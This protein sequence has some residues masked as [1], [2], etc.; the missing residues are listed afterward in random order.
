[1]DLIGN[2][3]GH[4]GA[5]LIL[6][7][8]LF[9]GQRYVVRREGGK[10]HSGTLV[11]REVTG[12]V[13]ERAAAHPSAST[14]RFLV[15]TV[16][17]GVSGLQVGNKEHFDVWI[18]V[19]VQGGF[20]ARSAARPSSKGLLEFDEMSIEVASPSTKIAVVVL[21]CH[22]SK[23]KFFVVGST[24]GGPGVDGAHPAWMLTF[25]GNLRL[26]TID[27]R[28]GKARGEVRLS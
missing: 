14:D 11:V 19:Y 5:P 23:C 10:A 3:V 25:G 26:P 13:G 22:R 27:Q 1:M 7:D 28:S 20:Y 21:A 8:L 12:V 18:E 2:V 4:N 24:A 15:H 6:T 16:R 17:F 9:E